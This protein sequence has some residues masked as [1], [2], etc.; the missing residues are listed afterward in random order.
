MFVAGMSGKV[1]V[2]LGTDLHF[3]EVGHVTVIGV[4]E[5]VLTRVDARGLWLRKRET[6]QYKNAHHG[7]MGSTAVDE[8]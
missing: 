2:V 8:N 6:L 7:M 3:S 1:E 4:W 5:K